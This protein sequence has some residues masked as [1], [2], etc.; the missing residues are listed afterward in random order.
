MQLFHG[1]AIKLYLFV[2]RLWLNKYLN[3][4][5]WFFVHSLSS[6]IILSGAKYCMHLLGAI[7]AKCMGAFTNKGKGIANGSLIHL[8]TPY[9]VMTGTVVF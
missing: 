8:P 4:V 9:A 6:F 1:M 2:A 3:H 7:G 5:T